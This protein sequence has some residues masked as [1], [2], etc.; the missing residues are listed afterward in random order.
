L[1]GEVAY[2]ITIVWE[3]GCWYVYCIPHLI[4]LWEVVDE[5]ADTCPD[6]P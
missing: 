3:A 1:E 5:K 4:G 2:G 6:D